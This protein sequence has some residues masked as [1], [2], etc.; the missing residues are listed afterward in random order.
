MQKAI[1]GRSGRDELAREPDAINA[2]TAPM[3]AKRFG[4]S[5]GWSGH[6][7]ERFAYFFDDQRLAIVAGPQEGSHVDLALAQGLEQRGS[8]QLVL[9]LPMDNPFATWQCA[10]WFEADARPHVHLHDGTHGCDLQTQDETVKR[11][12]ANHKRSPEVE[13]R[14]AATLVHLGARSSAVYDLVE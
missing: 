5:K 3:L 9:I 13:L 4:F 14:K 10:P 7:S 2:L 1:G 11:L 8:C 12:D 6:G